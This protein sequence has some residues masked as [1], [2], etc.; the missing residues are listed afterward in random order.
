MRKLDGKTLM[1]LIL[2]VI[3]VIFWGLRKFGVL[4][5]PWALMVAALS[6]A[7]S[8]GLLGMG[9]IT[10]KQKS[11]KIAGVLLLAFALLQIILGLTAMR[12]G[13]DAKN[14]VGLVANSVFSYQYSRS[15]S[16][17]FPSAFFSIRET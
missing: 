8:M 6:L 12:G 13:Y 4:T 3:A 7:V 14:G 16:S 2:L 10:Q 15:A 5:A 11:R 17:S 9:Y 1:E